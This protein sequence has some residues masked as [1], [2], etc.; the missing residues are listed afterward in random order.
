MAS[1]LPQQP[2][3]FKGEWSITVVHPALYQ[4]SWTEN[5]RG[6][7][8]EWERFVARERIEKGVA[9]LVFKGIVVRDAPGNALLVRLGLLDRRRMFARNEIASERTIVYRERRILDVRIFGKRSP[10]RPGTYPYWL[11]RHTSAPNCVLKV[12]D[13]P[14]ELPGTLR[15]HQLVRLAYETTAAIDKR[16]EIKFGHAPDCCPLGLLPPPPPPPEPLHEDGWAC[17]SCGAPNRGS[18]STCFGCGREPVMVMII[19]M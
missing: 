8:R 9:I 19:K 1:K 17:R 13:S 12:Y 7:E 3:L 6:R 2:P 18:R 14:F 4:V 15:D 16:R 11:F 10:L 5:D